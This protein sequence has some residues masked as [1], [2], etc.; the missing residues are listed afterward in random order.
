MDKIFTSH[1]TKDDYS[2]IIYTEEI[3]LE[4]LSEE[5]RN[6]L[7]IKLAEYKK[8]FGLNLRVEIN[9]NSLVYDTEILIP[10]KKH[11]D[12]INLFLVLGNPAIHSI[13][14]GMFFFLRKNPRAWPLERTPG[15]ESVSGR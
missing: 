2:K 3:N 4:F 12:R 5:A 6:S 9:E 13:S 14:E 7:N 8:L 10:T 11:Q 15:V 1:P